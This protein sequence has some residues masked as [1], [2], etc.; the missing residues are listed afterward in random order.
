MKHYYNYY[1]KTNYIKK[2][3][4]DDSNINYY[5]NY[6]DLTEHFLEPYKNKSLLEVINQ[7]YDEDELKL[8]DD[9]KLINVDEYK[10]L[11]HSLITKDF[12][13]LK[14]K[15]HENLRL[16]LYN[17]LKESEHTIK[18]LLRFLNMIE[19]IFNNLL[20]F[21]EKSSIY[22]TAGYIYNIFVNIE[23]NDLFESWKL[24]YL[25]FI[26]KIFKI[27]D[28]P[29]LEGHSI[30]KYWMNKYNF[31]QRREFILYDLC[32]KYEDCGT[33]ENMGCGALHYYKNVV[34]NDEDSINKNMYPF[35]NHLILKY[36][37][38]LFTEIKPNKPI[39]QIKK[40]PKQKINNMVSVC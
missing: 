36:Y 21:T 40:T 7:I 33:L 3:I 17:H 34:E 12:N 4:V 32:Q 5:E 11:I 24:K 6:E 31:E 13:N 1:K 19:S 9:F 26:F 30:K 25:I 20:F 23:N 2:N 37:N 27:F 18:D 22:A 10:F 28:V 14:V 8:N 39:K 35:I 16:K 38:N 29:I 15:K